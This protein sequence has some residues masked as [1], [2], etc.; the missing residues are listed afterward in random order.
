M[1]LQDTLPDVA[2]REQKLR[3]AHRLRTDCPHL[4]QIA[5]VTDLAGQDKDVFANN[6]AADLFMRDVQIAVNG[7]LNNVNTDMKKDIEAMSK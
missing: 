6:Y 2:N 3:D 5:D 1:N 7:D 4:G